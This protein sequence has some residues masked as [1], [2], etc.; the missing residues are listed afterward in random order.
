MTLR[1]VERDERTTAVENA[2]YR[3]SYLTLSVGLLIVVAVRSF[4]NNEQSWDL[5]ALVILGGAVNAGYQGMRR[6]T[7]A[8]WLMM[9]IVTAV[10]AAFV[11]SLVAMLRR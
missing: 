2:G 3:W 11:A 8:R 9:A 1:P 6:V 5:I 4:A 7:T 10:G